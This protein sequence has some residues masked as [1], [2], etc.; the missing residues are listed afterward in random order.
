M[1]GKVKRVYLKA[2]FEVSVDDLPLGAYLAYHVA[3]RTAQSYLE[4]HT[5]AP[6]EWEFDRTVRHDGIYTVTWRKPL[7]KGEHV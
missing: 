1:P 4:E 6:E 3:L 7:V 2:E 5:T